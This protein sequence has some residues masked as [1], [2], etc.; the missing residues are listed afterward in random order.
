MAS[1][2]FLSEIVKF[3]VPQVTL[4]TN[5]VK[6]C[7]IRH[8]II[9]LSGMVEWIDGYGLALTDNELP[10]CL[11][12]WPFWRNISCGVALMVEGVTP[13]YLWSFFE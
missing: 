3:L 8:S 5:R 12:S 6:S 13:L 7:I 10:F 1:F 4:L 11:G 9:R 2:I